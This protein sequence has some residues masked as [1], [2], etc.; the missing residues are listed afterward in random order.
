MTVTDRQIRELLVKRQTW[1]ADGVI[2]LDL[3]DPSGAELLEWSPGA[4]I[5]IIL[6]SG[7]VRQYS[8]CGDYE[9]RS[10]YRIAV[11]L[12]PN[13]RGGSR[14]IHET[15]LLGKT[16][17]IR[18]PRNHF[19][20]V[21]SASYLF[22]AGGIGVTP[23]LPM[24]RRAEQ[25]GKPWY[26]IYGGRSRE[27]MA[28]L[29]D[30][31]VLGADNVEV[32]PENEM[33]YPDI[34]G[35]V[36]D[37]FE[38]AVYACGPPGLL[39]VVVDCC[40]HYLGPKTAHIERFEADTRTAVSHGENLPFELELKRSGISV[41]VRADETMLKAITEVIPSHLYS[42]EEGY[43]GTCI[44]AVVEGVPEHRDTCL[45][46]DERESNVLVITCVSRS[47]TPRLVLDL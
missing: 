42:C 22:V 36:R 21:D 19:E 39:N 4:H 47:Q 10:Y 41:T 3:V 1:Q 13:S 35:V 34:D 23:I 2:S 8:L 46:D 11:L 25:L 30:L 16:L 27:S 31:L 37:L 43:C 17:E 15:V 5:D 28:F 18:G 33:G 7:L 45:L 44:A 9:D 32:V 38:T 6:P 29:D 26:L 40:D 12:D 20:L 24:A 14:Q